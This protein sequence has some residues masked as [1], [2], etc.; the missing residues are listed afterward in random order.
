MKII[1]ENL[2]Q[3]EIED[4]FV[5]DLLRLLCLIETAGTSFRWYVRLCNEPS[6]HIPP[7]ENI[8][9][10]GLAIAQVG[11]ALKN[12]DG[13]K[14]KH[15]KYLQADD[16]EP[17]HKEN[18]QFLT[19]NK[20]EK[21][22]EFALKMRDRC[23]FHFDPE[24]IKKILED[25]S[26]DGKQVVFLENA[27]NSSIA[28]YPIVATIIVNNIICPYTQDDICPHINKSYKDC[29]YWASESSLKDCP[30]MSA[31]AEMLTKV[32]CAIEKIVS[33]CLK[34]RFPRIKVVE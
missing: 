9:A 33:R 15:S 26:K 5:I 7:N 28:Y 12:F 29:P 16:W 20:I 23:M 21:F 22:R 4:D 25:I 8:E 27:E 1:L 32:F 6:S 34:D 19:S 31:G 24:P 17:D 3:D 30:N 10:L 2:Q 11:E 14:N 13:F 18:L